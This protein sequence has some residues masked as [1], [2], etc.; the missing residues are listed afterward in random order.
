MSDSLLICANSQGVGLG[1]TV[2]RYAALAS[3]GL[4]YD[5]TEVNRQITHRTPGTISNLAVRCSAHFRT[6]ATI[7]TRINGS[8]GTMTVS[9][10]ASTTGYFEDGLNTDSIANGDLMSYSVVVGTTVGGTVTLTGIQVTFTPDDPDI[11]VVR[12]AVI[13]G[14]DMWNLGTNYYSLGCSE[15]SQVLVEERAQFGFSSSATIKNADLYLPT[16]SRGGVDLRT[17]INGSNGNILIDVANIGTGY[18][19]DLV[20]TDSIVAD[21]LVCLSAAFGAVVGG[22]DAIICP[23]IAVDVETTDTSFYVINGRPSSIST[24]ADPAYFVIGGSPPQDNGTGVEAGVQFDLNLARR[25]SDLWVLIESG[26][27]P[28]G[29]FRLMVRNNGADTPL[30]VDVPA[31]ST[32]QF[33]SNFSTSFAVANDTSIQVTGGLTGVFTFGFRLTDNSTAATTVKILGNTTILGGTIL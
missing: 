29:D 14:S 4:N 8:D 5:A 18:F 17:R 3:T 1:P 31:G 25:A 6:P 23:W 11:T 33:T 26:S 12:Y 10:P 19:S 22:S 21:D 28:P 7:T 16:N 13:N 9:I 27:P 32:G 15:Q 20:N 2:T 30:Y 24:A